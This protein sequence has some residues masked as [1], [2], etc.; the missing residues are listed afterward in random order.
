VVAI[1]VVF[2]SALLVATGA[3]HLQRER[4]RR[5]RQQWELRSKSDALY[6]MSVRPSVQ[7]VPE[8]VLAE[9]FHHAWIEPAMLT[10]ARI[11][12]V[13][14]GK[15]EEDLEYVMVSAE[16]YARL[17]AVAE[18]VERARKEV[19]R[20]RH[21]NAYLGGSE[22]RRRNATSSKWGSYGGY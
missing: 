11:D 9:A 21:E 4:Q 6:A 14:A 5:Q 16:E 20:L 15:A 10:C 18:T 1:L 2:V 3:W 12:A 22:Y 8:K 13:L 17:Q 19:R 7:E